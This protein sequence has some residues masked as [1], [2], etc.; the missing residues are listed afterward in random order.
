MRY[1]GQI[2]SMYSVVIKVFVTLHFR[3]PVDEQ[4]TV[5]WLLLERRH[6]VYHGLLKPNRICRLSETSKLSIEQIHRHVH[7]FVH[8]TRNLWRQ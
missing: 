7:Q 2:C 3:Y 8:D 6:S 4:D 1:L 5:K